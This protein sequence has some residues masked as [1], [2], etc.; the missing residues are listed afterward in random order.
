MHSYDDIPHEMEL[1]CGAIAFF[2]YES[3]IS[4]RCTTC[5]TIWGSVSNPCYKKYK[6]IDILKEK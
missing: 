3:G 2:D 5:L 6:L 4:Y 1:P